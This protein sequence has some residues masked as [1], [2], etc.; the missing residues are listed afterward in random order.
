MTYK[1]LYNNTPNYKTFR[2]AT[3]NNTGD[4]VLNPDIITEFI[5]RFTKYKITRFIY[6]GKL[7]IISERYKFVLDVD[8]MLSRVSRDAENSSLGMFRLS[9]DL[10]ESEKI[11]IDEWISYALSRKVERLDLNLVDVTNSRNYQSSGCETCRSVCYIFP[12][13]EGNFPDNLKLLKSLRL[14][15]VNVS[16]EVLAHLMANCPL[17][18]Q[19]SVSESH[20]LRSLEI[21]G[22]GPSFKCLEISSCKGMRSLVIRDSD[23]TCMKYRGT[24]AIHILLNKVPRLAD[25]WVEAPFAIIRDVLCRFKTVLSELC[26]L[27]I[28]IRDSKNISLG[29]TMHNLKEFVV[30]LGRGYEDKN[31]LLPIVNLLSMSP[32]LETFVVEAMHQEGKGHV[33]V[34]AN[35]RD[36]R[37]YFRG[38][39]DGGDRV[40]REIS[41]TTKSK[42]PKPFYSNLKRVRFVGYRGVLNHVE[43]IVH[44]V[45]TAAALEDVVLGPQSFMDNKDYVW[46]CVAWCEEED[47]KMARDLAKQLQEFVSSNIN[48]KIL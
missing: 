6:Y 48:F 24:R 5:R 12:Y 21:S 18:E 10:D 26:W 30:V 4:I 11:V 44:L 20:V 32:C 41:K 3:L 29:V 9:F 38:L 46:D 43:M 40:A 1:I 42:T 16:G 2:F 33:L 27:K 36:L 37:N 31:S 39:L 14:H 19:V 25:L 13:K 15:F 23:L 34:G 17:L 22:T 47:E 28:Y 8:R 35:A 7:K 45:G